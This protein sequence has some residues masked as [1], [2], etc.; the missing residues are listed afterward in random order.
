M[1]RH[2]CTEKVTHSELKG[3]VSGLVFFFFFLLFHQEDSQETI[4]GLTQGL[5]L[6]MLERSV[7]NTLTSTFLYCCKVLRLF[8]QK[9]QYDS[10]CL[11]LGGDSLLIV[12]IT[13]PARALVVEINQDR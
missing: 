11:K 1:S 4:L 8:I 10:S 5:I 9:A 12:R 7:S 6:H 2:P 3:V 13:K